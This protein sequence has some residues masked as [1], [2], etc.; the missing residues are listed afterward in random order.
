[1]KKLL[2]VVL[3]L[4]LFPLLLTAG[5]PPAVGSKAPGFNLQDQNGD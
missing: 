1:M 4:M 3:A 2:P 5:D